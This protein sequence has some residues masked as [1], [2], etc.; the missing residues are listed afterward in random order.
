MKR[1][2]GAVA[3]CE[4]ELAVNLLQRAAQAVTANELEQHLGIGSVAQW[5][6]AGAQHD[7]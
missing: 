1:A 7:C 3:E 2:I 4:S 5:D 6:S